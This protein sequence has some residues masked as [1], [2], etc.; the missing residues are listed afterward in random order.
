M[1]LIKLLMLLLISTFTI[2]GVSGQANAFINILTQNSGV[3]NLG[4]TGNIEVTVGNTGPVSSIN[5]NKVRAQISVPSA[6]VSV[7]PNVQQTGLPPGWTITVNTGSAIT[8]CNGSDVIPVGQAR[9]ILI[10][11]Q[12]NTIG[13]PSTVNGNLLFSSGTSCTIPGS[14]PG[15]NTAD[16]SSTTS[17]QVVNGPVCNLGVAASAGTILCNGGTTTLTATPSGAAGTVEYNLNGGAYQ[18][19]NV[20]TVNASGSPYTITAREVNNTSCTATSS[21]ITVSQPTQLVAASSAT[22]I[23]CNGG[24]S[25]VT[26]SATGGTAPY[27]GTGTFSVVAGTYSYTVTDANGCTSVTNVTISQ[28]TQLVAASSATSILCNGGN[29]TVTVSA[30]GGTAPYTG[31]GTFSVVAGTYSY[32]VTDANGC[33][34]VTNVTI[35]QPSAV[36]A[37]A[38]STPVTVVG[39]SNGTAT[40][41]ANGGTSPYTY[42]WTPSGQTTSTATGLTAGAY[43]VVVTDANGCTATTSVTV[44]TPA[45]NVVATSSATAILCNGDSSTVT[46]N[47][48]GG[49]A[50]YTGTG[51]FR[52]VAGTYTFNVTDAAGYTGVGTFVRTAG[53]YS[54]TVTD[55]N[56]C[57]AVTNVTIAQPSAVTASATSTPVTVVGGS[58]GTATVVANGGTSPYTYLWTPSGQTTATA[59]GLTAGAYSVVVTDANGCTASA[60][61]T[62][63]SPACNVVAS[64][65]ATAILCNGGNSTV[66]VSATGGTAPYTGVGTFV[67]TAGTYSFTVTDAAGCTATTNLTIAEPSLL[68]VASSATAILCN[69]GNSTVT[70]SATGGTAPYTGTGSFSRTAGTYNF[71]VTDANGCTAVTSVTITQPSAI[72]VSASAGTIVCNGGTTSLTVTASGGTGALQYSLNG[73]PP[74]QNSNT[75]TVGAGNFV[76]TVKDA[77]NCTA[78][79]AITISQP[80]ALV[81]TSTAPPITV[82]GGT[83]NVTVNATGGTAPYTGTGTFVRSAGTYSFTVTDAAGCATTTSITLANPLANASINI[84]TQNS[85]QV[86]QGGVVNIEVSVGNT[87]PTGAIGANRVRAQISVPIAIVSLLPN[88]QQT[89][90]PSGWTILTNNGGAITICN[91]SDI[92]PV[93][94]SRTILLKVQGNVVGGPST[95]TGNLLFSNGTSCS[96]PGSLPGDNTADNSSTSSI[97]VISGCNLSVAASAGT[98]LCNGGTTT[99]TATSS[100]AAGTV[101]YSLNGGAYQ[102]SNVFTVNALG[103]PYTITAR[104]VNNTSCTATSSPITVSQPTQLVAASSA[105]SILCN[106]GNSTVTV[107]ATGGTAPYTGTGTFSVVAGTYSYTVT[108]A[109]GCTSVTNVTI[110]QP[111]AVTASATSTPVTVV[112][113]SNGTAT[114]IANGGTA[115]YSYVWTPGGQTTSTATGLTAGAYSVVVTDAN[116]CT[117][118]TSVTVGSP[119][120]NV[121]ATSS[122]TAI[123][124][125]GDSSTVTVSATGG[126]APYTGVGTFRRVAGTYTFNITDAAGCTASTSVTINQPTQLVAASTAGTI[127]CPGGTTTV[128]VSASGGT[129]PYS[130]TGTFNRPLGSYSF[131]VTDANGCISVT[132]GTIISI[133]D[134]TRPTITA[135]ASVTVCAN[136]GC[137]ATGVL[138]GSPITADNCAVASVTNNAPAAFPLGTTTVIWTVTDGSGNTATAS[139]IVIVNDCTAPTIYVNQSGLLQG[140]TGSSSSASPYML[141]QKPGVRF[142]SILS[143]G[144]NIGGY[145]M[146]GIPDGLGAFDNNDGTFSL[147]MNHELG[148]T[149]GGVRVHGARGAFVSKW[150]INKLSLQV[151]SGSDLMQQVYNWNTTSQ[152]SNTSTSTIAFNRFCSAD[153]P[154]VSA[155]YNSTT[156]LGTKTR[157]YMHGEEGGATGYQLGSVANGPDAGK[158]Y[159]LGKFNLTTNGSG[160]TGIGAWENAL[161]NPFEQNKT[162]VIGLNDGGTGIMNNSVSLYVGTKTNTGTEVDKAGLTNGTLNFVNVTGNPTEIV[163]T[164]TRA[165]NIVSGSPFTLSGTSS[166]VFSRPEDGVWNPANP[167]QFF[168]LTTDQY[169]QVKDGVG[170]Q[171]GRS[172]LWR[173]NFSDITNPSLGGTIDVLLDGTEAGNMFDNIGADKFGHLFLQE[174]VGNQQHNGKVWQYTIATDQLSLLAKHDPARFGDVGQPATAPFNQDEETSGIIDASDILG[175]GN[176]LLVDQAHYALASPLVEGGQLMAMFNP[177]SV[178]ATSTAQDTLRVCSG[179][180]VNL[181]TPAT[182]D[183][184]SIAS[185]TNNAPATFPVGN[186]TVTWTVTDGSG[187]TA[188]ATQVVIVSNL[189]V[190][191]TSTPVTVVGGSNGTATAV[192][193]GGTAPY[194]YVWT[195]GGQTTSTATGLTAGA[196]SVVV[197]DAN[198]CT[199]TTSVTVGSPACNVVATSSATAILCNGDSSTVTVNATGGTAPYTGTGTFRRVAGTYTFNVTDAAGCTASTSVTINQPTQLVVA[200]SATSILCNGGNST[201]TVSATGGTAPYTGVGTFVRTAGSYS[202]TVTDANGC[203]AVTNVTIAQPTVL[204]ANSSATAILCNGGNSTV[205]VNA[206]GGTAPYT[207]TGSFSR[208]AGTYNFIVT[209]ANGCTANTSIT[210]AQPTAVIVAA[211]ASV[212]T[213]NGGS[214]TV[215]VSAT[216]GTAPYT[217]TGNFSRTAGT[218]SFTVT[219]ANGCTGVTTITIVQPAAIVVTATATPISCNGGSSTVTVS[220]TGGTAPYSGTGTF[221]VNAGTYTY[222][223][224]D[225]NECSSSTTITIAQPA[226]LVASSSATAILCNGGSSTVTVSATGGTA[227]YTGAG[228]F[229]RTAGTYSFTITDAKGCTAVTTITITQ[230]TALVVSSTATAISCN[231][232]SS[233]VTITA[234]GGTAPYTGTGTF[235]RTAGTYSFTV[236][237]ANGCTA[238]TSITIAQ[239]AVLAVTTTVTAATVGNNGTATANA[240][241]G[242]APYTY[243]WAPGGQTTQTASGLAAGTY[244]VTVTDSKGCIKTATATITATGGCNLVVNAG[245]DQTLCNLV[246]LTANVTGVSAPIPP[247]TACNV[248][249]V[250]NRNG[251]TVGTTRT[252]IVITAGTYIVTATDCKGCSSTDTVIVLPKTLMASATAGVINCNNG[253]TSVTVTATGGTAPYFGTGTFNNI[254]AGTYYFVVIDS[255]GCFDTAKVTIAQ[256]SQIVATATASAIACGATT[257]TVTVSATGGT[258]PYTGIGN[259]VRPAGSYNFTVTDARGCTKSVSITIAPAPA[260]QNPCTPAYLEAAKTYNPSVFCIASVNLCSA[261]TYTVPSFIQVTDG[262]AGNHWA[263]LK[264]TT[265]SGQNITLLYQGGSSQANPSGNT[266]INLGKRWNYKGAYLNYNGSIPPNQTSTGL[267]VG[268]TFQATTVSLKVN[269]SSQFGRTEG[270]LALVSQGCSVARGT[271]SGEVVI[272][273]KQNLE[274]IAEDE[275]IL[276]VMPNPSRSYFNLSIK[277]TDNTTPI[278]VRFMDINGKLL[279]V[280]NNVNTFKGSTPLRIEADLLPAGVYVAEVTQGNQR[281]SVKMIKL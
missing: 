94:A 98:I 159:I 199:A 226:V 77:N 89:G 186:T 9:T 118:T 263:E 41:I 148:S 269:G 268:Q 202:F 170:A 245:S 250:W 130:G 8:V 161:A 241:G 230:P 69:G 83:T 56:G 126:T 105:T 122:A 86:V 102:L 48:T 82:V 278:H 49:T 239:P 16:N 258:A 33:T 91:G 121:V 80:S 120:C 106:G 171:V 55:A 175:N 234:I 266:Q 198:G 144:D 219:D 152:S 264:Y 217:G 180:G 75:F 259:F 45:C 112:G 99:L 179:T 196:H 209:D 243:L 57:I 257:T 189:A 211:T 58:N 2:K 90:L 25:T 21:P 12:G 276:N 273:K 60:S 59:T 203:I 146:V 242:T 27:T 151:L 22:S 111:S 190:S 153:L 181:G 277:T 207:G 150:V 164:A 156:G 193:T 267:Q 92:I 222:T 117:A 168:F 1:K 210:I 81:A 157:I 6:I 172:R 249:Y 131:I 254:P 74:F 97:Q 20:F 194:S 227:P 70:V 160:L 195:P 261:A 10:K 44:G 174:D 96:A 123:L 192:V 88:A 244:T 101:E 238:V 260:G 204:V 127:A 253:K 128:T 166:T 173:L 141:A 235:S 248:S 229:S 107:S 187:N 23:L 188:T 139:Q 176:H 214:S 3:V 11:I 51:T 63:G 85:G 14:L 154:S 197:T 78:T 116:G 73:G 76:V 232:G 251:V 231:S 28:P 19:S 205:T 272:A 134:T 13:G 133:P 270:T 87:G 5:A 65:S 220:A 4:G 221:N 95:V 279:S 140:I 24:N 47:A 119:A 191:A 108:D 183:N 281:K 132:S 215:V 114:V 236:T 129:A 271:E 29:S 62:V 109:N 178:G 135:P 200:S 216:G 71:T 113:G 265:P 67:R 66:T 252:I 32:T 201:V 163:N 149:V 142:K 43:S 137:T 256:P 233:T 274:I 68:V 15:D 165:T 162:V 35:A 212:I 34:S 158:S 100:G 38:T 52:R 155:F 136:T 223:V 84:L 262:N 18:S 237:D 143:V 125:N 39:G 7:L 72:T 36:T 167:S 218:Y 124:C 30:T 255:K 182:S 275:M 46:I 247:S 26:V 50:P 42:L 17:V 54:F 31:T 40:V 145:Q 225:A 280:F 240:T 184:C 64:A 228:T 103:S 37:S 177:E 206:S 169:D 61:T 115:P 246:L 224:M 93:G 147:L 79:A 104:E 138:L 208:I 185:V 110:A 53:S 213:C